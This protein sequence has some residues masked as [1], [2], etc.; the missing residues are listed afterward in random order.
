[1]DVPAQGANTFS[2]FLLYLNTQDVDV[3]VTDIAISVDTSGGDDS[4]TGG[5][6]GS[7]AVT[8]T[9]TAPAGTASAR[10]HSDALGW[11]LNHA[12]GVASDNGDGTWT[13]TIPAPW[14]ANANYKWVA[15]GVEEN[16]KD[17]VDAGYCA[18]DG[19]N[20][21]DWGANRVYSGSGDV[22][23]AVFGECSDTPADGGA[24]TGPVNSDVTFSVDMTGVDLTDGNPT[25]QSTFNSW[26]G[27]CNPMSDDD[28]DNIWT[29]TVNIPQGDHEYKYALGAWV[30][31]EAVPADCENTLGANRAVTVTGDVTLATDV[32]NGCPVGDNGGGD[33]GGTDPEYTPADGFLITEAFG[34]T[35]IG[36]GS[37]YT[38]PAGTEAWAGFANTNT[39]LY[40]ITVSEDSV[41]TFTGSVPAGGDADVRFRFEFNPHPDVDP[42]F[43]TAAV[44]VSGAVAATYSVDVPAQG[45]NTF[46]SFLLYLNTQDVGV[47]VTDIAISV[48]T[49][50]GDDS[51][52][53]GDTGSTA[54]TF[55]VTAPAGTASAR[56]HSDALG[57]DLNHADGV[58]SDNGDGTWTATIPA[59]WGANANYKWVA[60][61]VEENLK[62]DVDAGYCA[63]DGLNSG[64]WGAN[65]V[66]SGSGDV[67]G[68]VFGEC[69]DTPADGGADTGPVN[70]DVTFSVDMTG[71]DLTDGNPTLQSTFNSWCGDCNPM[72][73]DDGDNIW[74]VTVNI[75]QGDHEYK[76]ALGAWVSQE[77]V[78]ADCENTLG[79]NRAVTVTGDVTLAT[80]VYNGC[81]VG[82]NGGG[83]TGGT[84]PEYTPAD[85]FLITEA[86]GGTT[87]GDGSVYTYPAGTE[88][89][90]GFANTNTSLYPITVSEDSVITF[91]G[92]VPAGGDADVRFRFEFNPHPDVDPSF[93]TAAVTVSGA[94]AATYSVDV[95]AQGANTFSSFLLYLNT[96]DVGV[97]VTDIAIS[98]DTSGG[99]DSDT[100]GDTGST[101]V[102]FTVTAPAG[103]ASARLH[104]DALGWD[105]NHADG[106]ASD[107]GDG[108]WTAT[109]PA[110]WGANANYKWVADGVEENLK[111]DVD[112]GYCANDGLNSGDWGANRVYSGSGDVTGAVFG[113]CSDTP[114]D[115][116]ADTGPVNSDVTFSVDMTGVDLTDGNP[117]LQS[118]F[119]SWCG[120]C[121]PMLDDDGDN[122]WTVTVNI[123]QGDHEYK[124][125]LGAWVSQEAVPADCDN[126]LGAN[127]A[128]TVTGDVTL[129]TDV[130]N[131]CPGDDTEWR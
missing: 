127:R 63:N 4:D 59:P 125:A 28:G 68:A 27:D 80:D 60:D 113:E 118:T 87:I 29:V 35:T 22:T 52:T 105:L 90:A 104:S 58:A 71:V 129:A 62:D 17:D 86:F 117:T 67:T 124:Y 89:W 49:S 95:P 44:T 40:P 81:P 120:G 53:G 6:T 37:V 102:T 94:V 96:Q 42:S 73:D 50:G 70:S 15:D 14:G 30:S 112:A 110:P 72:S 55:T 11:D 38:Y 98:V 16:L 61:G 85:G 78:P 65:R 126:T 114:A 84:D 46:S 19:L 76:Y 3:V 31:Q 57:W 79:A 103:T 108:T 75:P 5:D 45:A 48:D 41:I 82:D 8:F 107:N 106:V 24:D 64:D 25:L 93:N 123:P 34:G 54:V 121:N 131:G 69:S 116:G 56:L 12:D 21:G 99:D 23:G 39:S 9:V 100:G 51:D 2:S 66:Y 47:V 10:L 128:V 119:N 83:D 115:G 13:A 7:T 91:T 77:A 88:A 101:A 122:I 1:M 111:D 33:T 74:T 18:N 130:Y 43:N 20:S 92:S 109:I 32:Y 36:D 97:V 26:C